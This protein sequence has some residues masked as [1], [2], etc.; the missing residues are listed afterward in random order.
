MHTV[1]RAYQ[2]LSAEGLVS[3]RRGRGAVVVANRPQDRAALAE[4]VEALADRARALGLEP[5]EAAEL[6]KGAMA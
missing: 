2:R 6:L 4:L 5:D 3:M 1:L